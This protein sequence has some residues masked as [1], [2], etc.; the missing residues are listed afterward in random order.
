MFEVT[1]MKEVQCVIIVN[2]TQQQYTTYNYPHL[3][4]TNHRHQSFLRKFMY[5]KTQYQ[6]LCDRVAKS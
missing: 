3:T 6:T 5:L 1:D 4:K 2:N